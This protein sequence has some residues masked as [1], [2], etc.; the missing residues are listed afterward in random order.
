LDCPAKEFIGAVFFLL[1]T[2]CYF[3]TDAPLTS[4]NEIRLQQS[5]GP[6]YLLSLM[7]FILSMLS[8]GSVVIL[9]GLL[10]LITWWRRPL[11]I[12]DIA[13]TAPF[14]LVGG[15]LALLNVWFQTHGTDTIVRNIS[16][17]DRLLGAG[18]VIWFYLQGTVTD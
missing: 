11:T 2:F 12:W 8:K 14:F 10:L 18:A 4:E 15:L 6:W 9:P 5:A 3:K 13:R 16:A 17:V 7:L 1:S